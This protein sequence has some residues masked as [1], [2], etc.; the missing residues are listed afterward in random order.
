MEV[1]MEGVYSDQRLEL[2]LGIGS[3][4]QALPIV[5]P[6]LRVWTQYVVSLYRTETCLR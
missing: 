3:D 4:M 2:G 5:D 6:K 1:T